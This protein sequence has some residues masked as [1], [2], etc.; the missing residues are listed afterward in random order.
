[1]KP[2]LPDSD[3][4]ASKDCVFEAVGLKKEF[5]GGQVQTLH[6]VDF[7]IAK[8]EFVAVIGPERLW[9]D[10]VAPNARRTRPAQL[11]NL[12]TAVNI[13]GRCKA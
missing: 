7:Q 12:T 3:P 4:A 11:G 8:G 9:K 1:M 13:G 6:G 5:D 10:Y 2:V